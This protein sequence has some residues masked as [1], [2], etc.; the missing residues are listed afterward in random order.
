MTKE[1]IEVQKVM[2]EIKAL[3][4]KVSTSKKDKKPEPT[5]ED[6]GTLLSLKQEMGIEENEILGEEAE[7]EGK[8]AES[9]PKKKWWA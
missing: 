8:E 6:A 1:V 3:E 2:D 9:A 5:E 7:P 4:Q